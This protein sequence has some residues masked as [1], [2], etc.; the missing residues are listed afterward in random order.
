M[1]IIH[2][3]DVHW[4]GL[5]RH[6]EYKSSFEYFFNDI[7]QLNP[8]II[9]VGGDIVH[10]KTHGISPELIQSLSWWFKSL[11]NIA[12]THVILGNHDGLILNKDRQDTITPIIDALD[13]D[14][15]YLYKES[16]VY[17]VPR[18]PDF[19]FCVFSCFDEDG[20]NR[21][22]P[23]DDKVN[24]AFYHGSVHRA[25]TDS[26]WELDGEIDLKTLDSF[27]F[28]LL[29]DI[30][31]YQYLD[32]DK[33]FAYSGSTIQQNYGESKKK[34]Y[35]VWDITDKDT[36]KSEYREIRNDYPFITLQWHGNVYATADPKICVENAKY[37]IRS[38]Y[39]LDQ[40]SIKEI[41][42]FL[43]SNYSAQEVVFKVDK[44]Q[45][46]ATDSEVQTKIS[47]GKSDKGYI[48]DVVREFYSKEN[49]TDSELSDMDN[50][51][52]KCF[53]ELKQ[54]KKSD[55]VWNLDRLEFSNLF[56]Y[57]ENNYID[58]TSKSGITGIFGKNRIGKSSIIGAIMYTLFNSSDR[59]SIK[60]EHIVNKR[61]MWGEGTAY[62]TSGGIHYRVTRRTTLRET[63]KGE[64]YSKTMLSIYEVT[65]SGEI[66]RDMSGEQRRDTEIILRKIIG[67]HDD[68][69]MTSAA[70][71]GN[72]NNFIELSS[73][74]RKTII[75][76][77]LNVNIFDDLYDIVRDT[78]QDNRV[79]LKKMD[80]RNWSSEE[81]KLSGM[82]K[83]KKN[84]I[85]T[86]KDEIKSEKE[87]LASLKE[88]NPDLNVKYTKTDLDNIDNR[89]RSTEAKSTHF[90]DVLSNLITKFSSIENYLDNINDEISQIDVEKIRELKEERSNVE[91][92]IIRHTSTLRTE[93]VE[94]KRMNKSAKILDQVPCGQQFS[95]CKFIK[96]SY[97]DKN[98]LPIQE[99][100][101][102]NAKLNLREAN[103]QLRNICKTDIDGQLDRY[104]VLSINQNKYLKQKVTYNSD[105]DKMQKNI[106]LL[107]VDLERLQEKRTEISDHV[108]SNDDEEIAN[109]VNILDISV[110][111]LEKEMMSLSREVGVLENRK[112]TLKKEE[113]LFNHLCQESRIYDALLTA[114]SKKG[115]PVFLIKRVLPQINE[116]IKNAIEVLVG[117]TVDIEYSKKDELEIYINYGD[118]KR[119]I[120]LCSGMEKMMA[121]LALRFVLTNLSTLPR[122]NMLIIDEGF[123]ALDSGNISA[124]NEFLTNLK[125][126]YKNIMIISHIDVIKDTVDNIMEITRDVIDTKVTFK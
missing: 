83:S 124:C 5:V 111:N 60:N 93:E 112:E 114:F 50:I 72:M 78:S 42:K 92:I 38:L 81:L 121:S 87:R 26:G 59:G 100:R 110:R 94:L 16:G 21:I 76:K 34:G 68:F 14:N 43:K 99:E 40:K 105:I 118:S 53:D 9:Y 84:R 122:S 126:W 113:D 37:R 91:K 125:K 109:I 74:A 107:A 45:S 88:I 46:Y 13:I 12:D 120:E 6:K 36:Y 20:W 85:K 77:F 10:S 116:E 62:I 17:N 69:L 104:R 75:N 86:I 66:I 7:K 58:F 79:L 18:F 25:K 47:I 55:L 108:A 97:K 23:E 70:S 67:Q 101:V 48:K 22:I 80:A 24:I 54:I 73:S 56:S 33:R 29:G 63:K 117:F 65:E 31:R 28:G 49:F 52:D 30:H 123:G 51:I 11:T 44:N 96:N 8:D 102:K 27:D 4:R 89:I 39:P 15:L 1:K 115:I 32:P 3:A 98:N 90:E 19:N 35:I 41:G 61:K 64:V 2:I 82:M 71:Q 57:G 95:N 103:K 119:I 106:D